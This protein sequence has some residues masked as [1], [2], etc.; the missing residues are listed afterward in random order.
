MTNKGRGTRHELDAMLSAFR[1]QII[2][3][4]A[5][6][7]RLVARKVACHLPP[8]IELD[9]LIGAGIL[10]LIEA[11]DRFDPTRDNGFKTYAEHRV[12]GAMLDYL[13][14]L[15]WLPR[16]VRGA[17]K[18]MDRAR[19]ALEQKNG[20][21]VSDSEL[22]DALGIEINAYHRQWAW[23][24][25]AP[26]TMAL[27]EEVEERVV[28]EGERD[29]LVEA[30]RLED[31]NALVTAIGNLRDQE[32]LVLSLYY[33]E[34]LSFREIAGVMDVSES[35]ICQIHRAALH[36]LRKVLSPQVAPQGM[37]SAA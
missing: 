34:E 5:G 18:K 27:V 22:C 20:G 32:R 31:R 9:D 1:T 19:M 25:L 26:E 4:Y 15:D 6:L 29:P 35:R 36:H 30:L 23:L 2:E 16:S 24:A 33:T 13:R 21:S 28:G 11:I 8:W 17:F 14:D 12:R 3:D 7:V 37:G 10:G